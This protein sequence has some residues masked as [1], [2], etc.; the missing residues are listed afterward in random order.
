MKKAL[1]LSLCVLCALTA[2]SQKQKGYVK[3]KGRMVNGQLVP[4]QGLKGAAVSV[5]DR[6]AILVNAEDG[7]FTF[8][9]TGEFFQ[10]DSV[11]KKGYQ[12]LM[13]AVQK[14]TNDPNILLI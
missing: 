10:L 13:G 3:T 4:G 11:T 6:T 1:L 7:A 8:P 12:L 2:F 9:T 14:W 5:K